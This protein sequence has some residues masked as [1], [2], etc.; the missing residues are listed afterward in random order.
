[1]PDRRRRIAYPTGR[2]LGVVDRP[3]DTPSIVAALAE[4]GIPTGDVE[5]LVGPESIRI[6]EPR[7]AA[8]RAT[9]RITRAVQFMTMDQLPDLLL[10]E[11]ALRDGKAVLA[12]RTRT[13][14]RRRAAIA[15]LEAGGAHF[16]N[17]FARFSTEEVSLWRGP[18][19]DLPSLLRR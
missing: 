3:A 8:G 15:A 12:V 16:L 7:T 2:L 11:A 13:D 6:L 14:A 17:V 4:A 1:M 18:E 9:A 19:P 5:V 10:Y